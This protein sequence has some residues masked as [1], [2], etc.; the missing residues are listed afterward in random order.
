MSDILTALRTELRG[1]FAD[2]Q[3]RLI[4]LAA[5]VIYALIYP[6][7]YRAEL[8]RDVP[9]VLV[10]LDR[11]TSSAE[12]AR[13]VT[14]SEAVTL[15]HDAPDMITATRLVQERRAY[16]V[17]VIP[18]GFERALLRGA[19]SPVALYADASYFLMYQRV[20]QGAAIPLRQMGAEV[21]MGR[22]IVQGTAPDV[23]LAQ[24]S[25]V[26]QIEV[27][28]FNPAAG[29]AT[30][31][32]PAAFV[33]I[34]QQTMLMGLALVASRRGSGSGHPV[35]RVLGRMG[36]WVMLYAA[37]LPLYLIIL[38]ALYGLPNLGSPGAVLMLGLP[39]VLATGLLAQCVAALFRRGE[40]VQVVL[41]A[42]GLPFFFLSGFAWPVEAI[43]AHLNWIAQIIPSTAA[44]D[45]LVRVS[46]MGATLPEI[47]HRLWHLWGL[48]VAFAVV[49]LWL[50]VKARPAGNA[51]HH[52]A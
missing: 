15:R 13:R 52:S 25:P 21:E 33:L 20:M 22:L 11:S 26:A 36:A 48:V 18:E 12:L 38:P 49:A 8:L 5:L 43:P 41:L 17:L 2:R 46:Q 9:V 4:I 3:V 42:V 44:I 50:E 32:L 51:D 35:W 19:Q 6:F 10:D 16:G 7:P 24:V 45:G 39:F 1:I 40:V 47:G 14:A 31:V 29:Y 23:S 37:L 27:P 34:L 30:Y 28:L